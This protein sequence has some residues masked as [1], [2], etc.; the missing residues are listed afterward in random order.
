MFS[1][2]R[3]A[4]ETGGQWGVINQQGEYVLEPVLRSASC[5]AMAGKA[6]AC[7]PPLKPFSQGCSVA[8][9]QKDG[10]PHA[11]FVARNGQVWLDDGPPDDL[12]GKNIWSFGRFSGGRAWFQ[13]MGDRLAESFGWIDA[14]G[15]VVLNDDFSGAGEFV[16]G[17]AP[18]ASGG[19]Y[20]WAYIDLEGNPAIDEDWPVY[21]LEYL[22]DDEKTQTMELPMT[23]ADFAVQEGRFRKHFRVAP[24]DTWNENMVALHEF[25]QMEEDDREGLF[26][27]IWAVDRKNNLIRVLVAEEI[28]RSTEERQAYWKTLKGLAGLLNKLDPEQIAQQVRSETAQKLATGLM[29]M[30]TGG[31]STS[32][33]LLDLSAAVTDGNGNGGATEAPAAA[34]A[35]AEGGYE[36]AWIDQSECTAC[37]ECTNINPKIFEYDD[38]KKAFV[39][40][41]K[42]GPYKDIVRAAE[43]C[44]GRC[45]HPGTPADSNEKGVDKLIKRAEKFQ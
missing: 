13:A 24:Q 4:V 39:K 37:D 15:K 42:G 30:L 40:D 17:L 6:D 21:K 1:E 3:A 11:F 43:K 5:A 25:I 12:S 14:Q 32:T 10:S 8:N 7:A 34:A 44:T 45:I 22:D 2:G 27:Y 31:G 41:A 18:A 9:V 29:S 35:T 28:V 19:R 36:P 16:D 33:A 26:P 38:R 20:S 23:F